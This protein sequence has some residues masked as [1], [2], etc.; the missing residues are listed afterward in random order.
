MFLRYIEKYFNVCSK[1]NTESM[2]SFC[3]KCSIIGKHVNS[4]IDFEILAFCFTLRRSFTILEMNL[5]TAP[6]NE[7]D[8]EVRTVDVEKKMRHELIDA[9]KYLTLR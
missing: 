9:C 7:I 1:P 5:N 6:L 8:S 2:F 4:A 3:Q